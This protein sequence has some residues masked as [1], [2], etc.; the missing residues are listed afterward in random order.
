MNLR[1]T[2]PIGRP[3]G[4]S[5]KSDSDKSEDSADGIVSMSAPIRQSLSSRGSR[6]PTYRKDPD[7]SGQ[8]HRTSPATT[9]V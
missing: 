4:R 8:H 7:R 9:R 2:P 1:D 3:A 6:I 5:E